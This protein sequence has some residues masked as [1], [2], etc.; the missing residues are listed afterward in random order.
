M[1]KYMLPCLFKKTFGFD[2]IGCGIQR[3]FLLLFEGRFK[4]AFFMFPAIYT[5][6]FLFFFIALHLL[7]KKHSYHKIVIGFAILNALVMIIAYV[8]KMKFIF[9]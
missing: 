1:E 4:E 7:E 6:L 8:Y 3:S 2:C 9:N 5:T